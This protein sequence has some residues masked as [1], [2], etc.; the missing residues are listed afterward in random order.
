MRNYLV[1]TPWWLRM[2]YPRGFWR[3]PA[4]NGKVVYLSFDDGPH[5]T[6]TPFVLSVLEEYNAKATFFCIGDNV[7]KFPQIFKQIIDRDHVVGNHTFNHLNGWKTDDETYLNNIRE[8][9]QLIPSNVFRP[10]Y[11]RMKKSQWRLLK[12]AFPEMKVIMWDVLSGDF[13]FQIDDNTCADNVIQNVSNGSVIVFHDSEKAFP[14]LEKA[15]PKVMQFL[16]KE[17][18]R[19]EV[20]D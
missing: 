6:I 13:D 1:K 7:R 14:R 15:L 8:A 11:G 4:K 19:F 18:Y 3:N 9:S 16:K 17:G 20:I 10:P 12:K 2:L 5:P